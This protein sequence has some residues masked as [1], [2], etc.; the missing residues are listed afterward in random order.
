MEVR[1]LLGVHGLIAQLVEQSPLKRPVLGSSPSQLTN[2][3]FSGI[4]FKKGVFSAKLRFFER[5]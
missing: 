4:G 1:F 2:D 3:N 5:K